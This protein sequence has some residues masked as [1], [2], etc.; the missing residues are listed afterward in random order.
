MEEEIRIINNIIV[1]SIVRSDDKRGSYRFKGKPC[2]L[3]YI[4]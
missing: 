1:E 2:Y 3:R 4:N